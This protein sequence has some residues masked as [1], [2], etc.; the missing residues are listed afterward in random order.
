M[1]DESDLVLASGEGTDSLGKREWDR[2]PV[3]EALE[4]A[5]EGD[6]RGSER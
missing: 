3:G 6:V 2:D 5:C 1:R 4:G